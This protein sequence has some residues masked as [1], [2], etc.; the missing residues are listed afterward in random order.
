MRL[1]L[2]YLRSYRHKKLVRP[3]ALSAPVLVLVIA[4][5]ML[6]PLRHP[7]P[8][9]ISDDEQ[10]RLATVQAIVERGSLDI[11]DTD[12]TTHRKQ[13]EYHGKSYSNQPPMMSAMLSGAYW[14]MHRRGLTFERD[15]ATVAYLLTLLGV[16][17]PAAC[18]AGLVYRMG[19]LFGFQYHFEFT[20]ADIEAVVASN[21]EE[22]RAVLGADAETRIRQDTAKYYRRYARLGD[23]VLQNFVQF[24]KMY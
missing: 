2:N 15:P 9:L 21:R 18:A 1:L 14:A 23:R 8:Q 22:A 16:T 4:L 19:R 13:I 5:P 10:A 24:L 11:D 7:D 12:F 17:I 20:E 3:W 6:R